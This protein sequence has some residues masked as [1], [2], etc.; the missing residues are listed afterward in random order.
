MFKAVKKLKFWSRKKRKRKSLAPQPSHCICHCSHST[1][2]HYYQCNYPY[3]PLQP[4][5]PPLPPW[6]Q[7]E[8]TQDEFPTLE[9]AEA[10]PFPEFSHPTD[11]VQDIESAPMIPAAAVPSYQQY[12]VS[13]PVYG[14]PVVQ[15]TG[16]RERSGGYFGCIIDISLR[17]I[18]CF[19]PCVHVREVSQRIMKKPSVSVLS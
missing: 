4:S 8:L 14:P 11:L 15:Q 2:S 18:R 5:A 16:R 10:E 17:L 13:N 3:S 7:A 6:L 19:C 1:S 9:Q 12:M